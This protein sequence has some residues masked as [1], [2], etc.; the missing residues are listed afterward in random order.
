LTIGDKNIESNSIGLAT[1]SETLSAFCVA[2][3]FGVISPKTRMKKV[4]TPVAIPTPAD[5]NKSVKAT[6]AIEAAPILTRLLPIRIVMINLCGFCFIL[7]SVS[8]PLLFCLSKELILIVLRDI[9]A[10]SIPEKKAEKNI[11]ITKIIN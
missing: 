10:V 8:D 11:R 9:K 3:V 7:C 5:P 2:N 6:V 4:I 1:K